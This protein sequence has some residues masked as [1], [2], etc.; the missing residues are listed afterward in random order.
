MFECLIQLAGELFIACVE[1]FGAVERNCCN[2]VVE[3]VENGLVV[4]CTSFGWLATFP[5]WRALFE[6]RCHAFFLVLGS[7]EHVEVLPFQF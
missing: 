7:K 5:L 1:Y 4:H 6:E 3:L 2:A